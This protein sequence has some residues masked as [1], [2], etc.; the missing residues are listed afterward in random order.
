MWFHDPNLLREREGGLHTSYWQL[1]Q[2]EQRF[3]I[4]FRMPIEYF[5]DPLDLIKGDT[6][7]ECT[8]YVLEACEPVERLAVTLR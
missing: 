2:Y 5:D 1:R 7:K 4:Y 6:E 8:N 3:C